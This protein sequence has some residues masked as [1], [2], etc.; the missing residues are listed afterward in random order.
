MDAEFLQSI[1]LG[2][3]QGLTEFLPVSSSGHLV[4]FQQIFGGFSEADLF[5]DIMLHIGTLVAVSIFCWR[6]IMMLLRALTHLFRKSRTAEEQREKR[7]F[8]AIL[9]AGIP[10]VL[11]GFLIKSTMVDSFSSPLLLAVTFGITTVLLILSRLFTSSSSILSP[12][13]ALAVGTAQGLAVLPGISRSGSTIVIGQAMGLGRREAARFAFVLAIPAIVGAALFTFKDLVDQPNL[14]AHSL[15][16]PLLCG[17]IAAAIVGYISLV[18][19]TRMIDKAA[20]HHFAWYTG[21]ICLF[22]L[23]RALGI[24]QL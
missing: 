13:I 23:L 24:I 10:T 19:L 8:I 3:V 21:A 12:R 14:T 9:I 1:L 2:I 7:L 20:F 4:L 17:M 16:L 11:F 18:L 5:E 15:S 22:C 6:E